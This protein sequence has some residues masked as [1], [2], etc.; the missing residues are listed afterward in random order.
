MTDVPVRALVVDDEPPARDALRAMLREVPWIEHV[1]DAIDGVD[2]VAALNRLKPDLVFMDV[3]M[4]ALSGV[5]AL[6]QAGGNV[7][8]I[9]TTAHDDY[10]MTAFELGAIDYLRKPFGLERFLL[11]IE[12]AKPNIFAR[13]ARVATN[14]GVALADR[15]AFAE[16]AERPLDRLYVRDRGAVLPIS[17]ADITHC[18]ADG[19]YVAVYAR[20]RRHLVYVNM[21]DLAAQLDSSRFIRVHRSHLVNLDA[22]VALTA[23]DTSRLAVRLK[24]GTSIVASRA[25]TQLLR[26]RYR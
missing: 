1:G 4:P 14:V 7:A 19:D 9:F 16:R 22:V 24:D 8:V 6:L 23:H 21:G 3:Q 25:G 20:G 10:A 15:L 26:S 11:A 17:V 2:A 13:R 12:R 18:D 5:E